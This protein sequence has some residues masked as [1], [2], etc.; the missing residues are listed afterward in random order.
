MPKP[1]TGLTEHDRDV[2]HNYANQV[3]PLRGR[4]DVPKPVSLPPIPDAKPASS[5]RKAKPPAPASE[6]GVGAAP[7]GLDR[8]TWT[9]FRTG[10]LAVARTLDLHGSTAAA[11]FDALMHFLPVAHGDGVRCVEI[12]T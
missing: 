6:L 8:A 9:R 2:W 11:A 10:K 3:R 4:V 1:R 7:A 5:P 12:I